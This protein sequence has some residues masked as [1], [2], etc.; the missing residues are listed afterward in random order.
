MNTNRLNSYNSIVPSEMTNQEL[1]SI[2]TDIQTAINWGLSEARVY[3]NS[4]Q[5]EYKVDVNRLKD[6][7]KEYTTE[8]NN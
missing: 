2:C 8:I 7:Q 6:Y 5:L 4:T 3:L 1:R